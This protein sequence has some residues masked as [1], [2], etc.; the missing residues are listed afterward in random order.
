V[1]IYWFSAFI[2]LQI[3]SKIMHRIREEKILLYGGIISLVSLTCFSFVNLI[4]IKILFLMLVGIS[5]S[6]IYPL[7]GAITIRENPKYAGTSS[8]FSIAMGLVGGLIV[9]PVMGYVAQ[10][11]SKSYIP[12]VLM[13]L[14]A[15]GTLMSVIL[16]RINFKKK[17][18]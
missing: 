9:S 7:C 18:L 11:L 17:Y 10:Y 15:L 14:A 13:L 12:Y 2:G 1:A 16:V 5:F 4:Y 6:G 3:I 8:G